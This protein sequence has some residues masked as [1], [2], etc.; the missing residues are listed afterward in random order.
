MGSRIFTL[1]TAVALVGTASVALAQTSERLTTAQVAVACAPPPVLS[2]APADAPRIM[3]SQDVVKR[4]TFGSP[5]LLV[6]NAGSARGIQINQQFFVRR[7]FRTAET[8]HDKLPHTVHTAGWV[9]VVAVNPAMSIV[10]PDHTCSDIR[11]GDYLEPF[12]APVLPDDIAA[13][14]ITG[15]LDF[16]NYSR[17]LYGA[18]QMRSAGTGNY[19]MINHGADRNIAVGSHFG[20]WR[21]LQATGIPLTSIGE[22]TAVA[23]G[24]SMSLLLVT[25]ARD[26]VFTDDVIVPRLAEGLVAE[27]VSPSTPPAFAPPSKADVELLYQRA[28]RQLAEYKGMMDGDASVDASQRLQ[29]ARQTLEQLQSISP[30]AFYVDRDAR[31]PEALSTGAAPSRADAE[32]IYARALRQLAEYKALVDGDA[33]VDASQRLQATRQTLEQ[34]QRISPNPPYDRDAGRAPQRSLRP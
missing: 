15:D 8:L 21:D 16:K 1:A 30:N 24:P 2:F 6:L 10:S 32:F 14:V 4:A 20:I 28:L 29:A 25:K 12:V 26:A 11:E 23:V 17:V 31:T 33:W 13:P 34:L 3:G 18:S 19:V 5:E 27:P 9:R 7:I 22:S